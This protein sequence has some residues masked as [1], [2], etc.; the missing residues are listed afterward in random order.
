MRM[1]ATSF[2]DEADLRAYNRAINDGFTPQEALRKG[3]NGL[4]AWNKSTV[5][6]TGPCCA[7]APTVEG[8]RRHAIVRVT[9]GDK[10]VDCDVRDIAPEGVID[11]NPDAVAALG[12]RAP[13][14]VMVDWFWL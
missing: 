6:G 10:F 12:L 14:S 1:K 3:D 11:L 5:A 2:A 4:G 13:L 7:L 8:F 9:F